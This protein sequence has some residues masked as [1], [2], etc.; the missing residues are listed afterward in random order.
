MGLV[1]FKGGLQTIA[2]VVDRAL[3]CLGGNLKMFSK[4][5]SIGKSLAASLM[6]EPDKTFKIKLVSHNHSN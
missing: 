6:V 5:V 3:G 2:E 1:I 4:R